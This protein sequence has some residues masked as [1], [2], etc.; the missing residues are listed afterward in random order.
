MA[1]EK[2]APSRPITSS[3]VIS[4]SNSDFKGIDQN[5]YDPIKISMITGNYIVQ[6][7]LVNFGSLTD[8]L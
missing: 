2:L 3:L 7:V 5:L 4:F 6:K 1:V 8:I